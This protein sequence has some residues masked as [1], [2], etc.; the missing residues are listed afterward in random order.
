M[1]AVCK[2][3]CT[4]DQLAVLSRIH[5]ETCIAPDLVLEVD[6]LPRVTPSHRTSVY[7]EPWGRM[8]VD[9][10]KMLA[11]MYPGMSVLVDLKC[12][13][14]RLD[15]DGSYTEQ[16]LED[17]AKVQP[18]RHVPSQLLTR[19]VNLGFLGLLVHFRIALWLHFV[20]DQ[21]SSK[22]RPL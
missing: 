20:S 10:T 18:T 16:V 21:G 1:V 8:T 7:A 5:P 14:F 4:P 13:P 17:I 11:R 12:G 2:G 3:A 22:V 9:L 6:I 15:T 19:F